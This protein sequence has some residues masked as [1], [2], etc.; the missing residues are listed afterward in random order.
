MTRRI[1]LG[2]RSGTPNTYALVDDEDY[3]W[4]N[5]W[6]WRQISSGYVAHDEDDRDGVPGR[7]ILMHRA[8]LGLT[9]GD[10]RQGDH[11]DRNPLNNQRSNLRIATQAQNNQNVPARRGSSSRHRG[12]SFDRQSSRWKAHAKLNG[13]YHHLGL[14]DTEDEAAE[15]ARI[16]RREHMPFSHSDQGAS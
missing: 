7:T 2:D 3:E 1:P 13:V 11:R 4:L 12:V 15:A 6:R 8:L 14:H 5:Q 9:F 10:T 16:F